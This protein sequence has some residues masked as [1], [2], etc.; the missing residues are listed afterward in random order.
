LKAPIPAH[1]ALPE[2]IASIAPPDS[3]TEL[4]TD[5]DCLPGWQLS[6]GR[7]L[8]SIPEVEKALEAWSAQHYAMSDFLWCTDI[9]IGRLEEKLAIQSGKVGKGLANHFNDIFGPLVVT[10]MSEPSIVRS[11]KALPLRP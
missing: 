10:R 7:K 9:V 11:R 2:I 6:N 3:K 5:P 4:K 8:R 1:R